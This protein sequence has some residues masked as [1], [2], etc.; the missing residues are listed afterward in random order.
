MIILR[1]TLMQHNVFQFVAA[2][3]Y[4]FS[5]KKINCT[6]RLCLLSVAL[7]F[8]SC[9]H[10]SILQMQDSE[11]FIVENNT[12]QEV[13]NLI[14]LAQAM[15]EQGQPDCSNNYLRR[16]QALLTEEEGDEQRLA[17][18]H[19]LRTNFATM[20]QFHLAFYYGQAARFVQ[21]LQWRYTT[22]QQLLSVAQQAETRW[23]KLLIVIVALF[24]IMNLLVLFILY[25][26]QQDKKKQP[27]T[28]TAQPHE[29]LLGCKTEDEAKKRTILNGAQ[30][31]SDELHRLFEEDKIYRQPKLSIVEVAEKLGVSRTRLSAV[32][33]QVLQKPYNDFV[34]GYRVAEAI[35]MLKNQSEGGKYA[36]YTIQA[37]A[38]AVGFTSTSGFYL[39]FNKEV[40]ATPTEYQERL[41]QVKLEV[42]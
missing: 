39:A 5:A 6:V 12:I 15:I 8:L 34:N 33:N 7:F 41:K 21:E 16:A 14:N 24:A 31:L 35:E 26:L 4:S 38:E 37:I 29:L 20:E 11:C 9:N 18:Y 10:S 27:A 30:Q 23:N 25:K 42:A 40:G 22:T 36:Q 19:G 1:P 3:V 2:T 32:F 28:Q 13:E 17:I